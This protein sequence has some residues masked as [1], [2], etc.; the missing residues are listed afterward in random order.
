MRVRT[1]D[2]LRELATL[3]GSL[4][5]IVEKM[6][7]GP[8]VEFE[9]WSVYARTE[10]TVAI[11]KLRMDVERPGVFTE[12]PTADQAED[13][14]P[15]ALGLMER[16]SVEIEDDKL[17]DGLESLRGARNNLRAYLSEQARTRAR[18]RRKRAVSRS[19]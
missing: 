7:S 15:K 12:L 8:P 19:S 3:R 2:V 17:T 11:L 9:V 10:K 1:E 14:L 13:F 16:A 4:E 18:A 5:R 6:G